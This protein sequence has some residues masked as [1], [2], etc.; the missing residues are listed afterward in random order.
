M[1]PRCLHD[2]KNAIPVGSVDYICPLCKELLD[3]MEWF[4]MNNFEFVDVGNRR[5]RIEK[6]DQPDKGQ[7]KIRLLDLK[8]IL[9]NDFH[10]FETETLPNCW[11]YK[12]N[13]KKGKSKIVNFLVF[14]N[15]VNDIVLRGFCADCGSR[16]DRY[17]E[18]GEVEKYTKKISKIRKDLRKRLSRSIVT[19]SNVVV[20]LPKNT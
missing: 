2:Y 15:D 3:P 10:L 8:T 20:K 12:C 1:G 5:R 11:C 13:T 7:T 14:L 18:I 9:G 19:K 4:F 16:L 6:I 17:V